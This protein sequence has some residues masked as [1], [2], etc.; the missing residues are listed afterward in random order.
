MRLRARGPTRRR[1]R[2]PRRRRR[3]G[4]PGRP[5]TRPTLSSRRRGRR[6]RPRRPA[7]ARRRRGSTPPRRSRRRSPSTFRRPRRGVPPAHPTR[8]ASMQSVHALGANLLRPAAGGSE[9]GDDW[10]TQAWGHGPLC[11]G[12]VEYYD[13]KDAAEG[14]LVGQILLTICGFIPVVGEPCDAVDALIAYLDG[15]TEGALLSLAAM[16]PVAGWIAGGK[17]GT[18]TS[19]GAVQVREQGLRRPVV[20]SRGRRC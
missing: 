17:R 16:I 8:A 18:D 2:D 7:R 1:R 11:D 15:D 3:P 19:A 20:S 10:Y 4:R 12:V 14:K 5:T 9:R 6:R 13:R